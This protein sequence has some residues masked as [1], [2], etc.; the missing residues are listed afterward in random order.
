MVRH[1]ARRI[2]VSKPIQPLVLGVLSATMRLL[3]LRWP[4][5]VRVGT[6]NSWISALSDGYTTTVRRQGVI[7]DL[8][9]SGNLDRCLYLSGT[10]E[11]AYLEFLRNEMRSGETYID[12]G[13]HIGLDA[14]I[15]GKA[16][17]HGRIV[18]FEPSP[19]SAAKIRA[20]AKANDL[21]M[22]QVVEAALALIHRK[23]EA[24]RGRASAKGASLQGK[25]VVTT[26]T[27]T[28][29]GRHLFDARILP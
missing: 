8:D 4:E 20:G 29:T 23:T 7:V 22:I 28:P 2:M 14:F 15:V 13:G 21:G 18:C 11:D 17:D 27:T 12:I 25:M 5:R 16:M 10:Y 9:L 3:R 6:Y 1:E 26:T 19:D 24:D